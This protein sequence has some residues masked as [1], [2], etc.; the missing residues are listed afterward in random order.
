MDERNIAH[1]NQIFD[2]FASVAVFGSDAD[3]LLE[4]CK[5]MLS[6]LGP[7]TVGNPV[8]SGAIPV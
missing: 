2:E 8:E 5:Q 7:E 3:A 1:Y 4:R 6:S